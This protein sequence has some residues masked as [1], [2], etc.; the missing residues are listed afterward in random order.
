VGDGRPSDAEHTRIAV[1]WSVRQFWQPAIETGRKIVV[2]L[3]NL[4]VDDMEI[5]QEPFCRRR[6]WLMRRTCPD[7]GVIGLGEDFG[8]VVEPFG[9]RA[10]PPQVGCDMLRRRQTLR[11]LLKTL[12]AEKFSTDRRLRRLQSSPAEH[13]KTGYA[14]TSTP[15]S[16]ESQ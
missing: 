15:E 14:Q 3:A 12:D 8:V 2:D 10:A 9:E 13:T 7:N 11:M 4:F 6:D 16:C 1:Q 5:V